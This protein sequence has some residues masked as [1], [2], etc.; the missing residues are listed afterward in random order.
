MLRG[1]INR[2]DAVVQVEGLAPALDLAP[3]RTRDLLVVVLADM[4]VDRAATPR[5]RGDDGD[6]P[7]TRERHVQRARDRR[8]RQREHVD[9]GAHLAQQLLLGHAEALLLVD[10]HEPQV[11]GHDIARQHAVRTDQ[12]VDLAV[13]E[14]GDDLLRLLG[15]A[16][17]RDD[18]DAHGQVHQAVAE[19]RTVLLSEDRGGCEQ[20]HLLARLDDAHRGAQ[21]HLRLAETDVAADQAV[22]RTILREVVHDLLDRACLVVGLAVGEALLDAAKQLAGLVVRDTGHGLAL[23][24]E[25]K[26]LACHLAHGDTRAGLHLQPGL[27]AEFRQLRLLAVGPDVARQL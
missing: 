1:L 27:A 5:R 17:A 19:R 20:E 16:H 22:H 12:E 26:Q 8:G 10:D 9:L 6:V 13:A 15:R 24:I 2:L 3:Q 7:Q 23:G 4:R 11:V 25:H 21:C 18:L 14:I